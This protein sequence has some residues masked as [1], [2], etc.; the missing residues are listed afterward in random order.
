MFHLSFE[1]NKLS[2]SLDVRSF[3]SSYRTSAVGF[4]TVLFLHLIEP[5]QDLFRG[6]E[7]QKDILIGQGFVL[8]LLTF[9]LKKKNQMNNISFKNECN[10][11]THQHCAYFIC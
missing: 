4:V 9:K 11:T 7:E 8:L 1:E 5:A 6:N 3:S 2:F 10:S